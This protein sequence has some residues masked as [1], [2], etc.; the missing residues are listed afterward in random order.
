MIEI[1]NNKDKNIIFEV[2]LSGITPK[3]LTGYFRMYIDGLEYGFP[4][5]ISESSITVD[6]PSLKS[7]VNR[8]LRSGE[9]IK[10]KLELVGNE[11][12]LVPWEDSVVIKSSVMV[13]AKIMEDG[14]SVKKP[15]VKVLEKKDE[16]VKPVKKVSKI[17]EQAPV[18]KET[19]KSEQVT[20]EHLKLFMRKNG[21]TSPKIQEI[22]LQKCIDKVGD[23]DNKRLFKELYN[24]YKKGPTE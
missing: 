12:Y 3:E 22:I 14:A 1:N 19:I 21:T 9:K 24:Y 15:M 7:I 17:K 8:P 18:I 11:N 6:I 16:Q 20:R 5:E 4:A 13:E 23:D 10:A 2:Q